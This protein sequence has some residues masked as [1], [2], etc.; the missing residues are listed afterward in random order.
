MDGFGHFMKTARHRLLSHDE[1]CALS[2][3]LSA[4]RA[5][6]DRLGRDE[7]L[8]F[9]VRLSLRKVVLN[10]QQARD[11]MV[12]H[13]LRLVLSIAKRSVTESLSVEDLFQE[14]VIG[15]MRAVGG[16]DPDRGYRFSTYATWW[17]RQSIERAVANQGRLIRIPVHMHEK[18]E[19]VVAIRDSLIKQRGRARFDDI[20]ERSGFEPNV[21]RDLLTLAPGLASLDA[22][23]GDGLTT[24]GDLQIDENAHDPL[25]LAIES[26]SMISAQT[27]LESL[28][29]RTADVLRMRNGIG[30]DTPLTLE[31]IGDRYNV[32]RERVRQI[33]SRG[34]KRLRRV[35]GMPEHTE[36]SEAVT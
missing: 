20:V 17:I 25:D 12:L 24:L 30:T 31:E 36:L 9:H 15:L 5:A 19:K 29:Q 3:E 6:A 4:G 21:V 18:L 22:V 1:M 13:N 32:T 33:E 16:F 34:L 11:E 10:G 14:G 2:R 26:E 8:S 35:C 23:V 7:S 27:L 28:D